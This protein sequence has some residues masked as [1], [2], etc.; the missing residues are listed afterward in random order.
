[1]TYTFELGSFNATFEVDNLTD[2]KLFDVYGVQRPGR[3]FNV[4]LGGQL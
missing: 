2:A 3:S 4:K 1:M